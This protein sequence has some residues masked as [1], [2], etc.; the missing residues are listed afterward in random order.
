MWDGWLYLEFS[1]GKIPNL[2]TYCVCLVCV[3]T[4]SKLASVLTP[5]T[6]ALSHIKYRFL[7]F[8]WHAMS[9][10]MFD[11]QKLTVLL[12]N[13]LTLTLLPCHAVLSL[14]RL[15][16]DTRTINRKFVNFTTSQNLWISLL[17]KFLG[18]IEKKLFLI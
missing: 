8:H 13:T 12:L 11:F 16:L 4:L 2:G 3:Y 14:C 6:K 15:D 9:S 18:S 10:S 17:A 5:G 1:Q 7:L